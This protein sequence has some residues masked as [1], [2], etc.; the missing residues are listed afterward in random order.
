[1]RLPEVGARTEERLEGGLDHA[2]C[3]Q[4]VFSQ[5]APQLPD[6]PIIRKYNE[7]AVKGV[8]EGDPFEL[9]ELGH[10]CVCD[11]GSGVIVLDRNFFRSKKGSIDRFF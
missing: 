2:M 5:K 10:R 1:M 3:L 7:N 11:M 9:R 4:V 8:R 6:Q